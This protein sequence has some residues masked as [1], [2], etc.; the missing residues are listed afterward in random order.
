MVEAKNFDVKFNFEGVSP[1]LNG[2]IGLEYTKSNN[3]D[4]QKRFWLYGSYM[5]LLDVKQ[6][7]TDGK[8][9]QIQVKDDVMLKKDMPIVFGSKN[10]GFVED[11]NYMKS[12]PYAVLFG[13]EFK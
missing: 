9:I 2:G 6:K 7:Y 11:V 4:K 3:S 8:R 1:L 13:F 10:I 12:K 5:D